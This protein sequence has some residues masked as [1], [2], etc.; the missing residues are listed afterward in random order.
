[1]YLLFSPSFERRPWPLLGKI[2]WMYVYDPNSCQLSLLALTAEDEETSAIGKK[3]ETFLFT[4]SLNWCFQV[5]R[6]SS[7][8]EPN[9]RDEN[10][11]CDLSCRL[12]NQKQAKKIFHKKKT[13]NSKFR[14]WN[15]KKIQKE[16]TYQ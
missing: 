11:I 16:R 2:I 3:I 14:N 5:H 13:K 8:L 6:P 1:M 12:K 10:C 15:Q 7:S 4:E 9:F